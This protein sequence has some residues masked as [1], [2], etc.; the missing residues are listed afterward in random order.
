MSYNGVNLQHQLAQQHQG[1]EHTI[2]ISSSSP[3]L[4]A[5]QQEVLFFIIRGKSARQIGTILNLSTR[6]IE[7]HIEN[8]KAHFL[9]KSKSEL[10]AKSIMNGY[11]NFMPKTLFNRN[12]EDALNL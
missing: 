2:T 6:T 4:T 7:S 8:M 3:N 5:R 9:V 12:L 11:A 10:I 1:V